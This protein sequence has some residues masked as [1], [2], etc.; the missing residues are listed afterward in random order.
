VHILSAERLEGDMANDAVSKR[1]GLKI[2][3]PT[4]LLV[5][6]EARV[7]RVMAEVLSTEGYSVLE[8]ATAEHALAHPQLSLSK[9]TLLI[10][11][12]ML[13]GKTGRQLARDL[14]DRMPGIK[15]ILVSGYGENVA[16]L[17]TE[18]NDAVSYLPKPFSATSLLAAVRQ[19]LRGG[20][21]PRRKLG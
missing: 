1:S 6:D 9:L 13:P 16:L 21:V 11:D 10:T 18:K 7:R 12:V 3:T 19:I 4:I 14:R 15:T 17:G 20:P 2:D 5:E 8:F